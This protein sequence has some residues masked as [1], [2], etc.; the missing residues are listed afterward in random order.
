MKTFKL[1][2][3]E[4]ATGIT[5]EVYEDIIKTWGKH[6]LVPV[7]GFWGNDHV[8]VKA[9]WD[10]VKHLKVETTATPKKYL[11]AISLITAVQN[12]CDRCVNTHERE[13]IRDLG[14]T[15]EFVDAVKNYEE[16]YKAGK[17]DR[18]YYLALELGLAVAEGKQV[19]D[20][21]WNGLNDCFSQ[22]QIYE[23][24]IIALLDSC[25]SR[26]GVAM[27]MFED[28]F[29]WPEEYTPSAKYREVMK[30]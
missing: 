6:R 8:V 24:I 27:A 29:D 14:L 5:K 9:M 17:L 20:E 11:F 10:V 1:V 16:S 21:L 4:Q 30:K 23:M 3:P 28:S 2:K 25:F 15:K 18:E 13:L 22:K 26:Y 12:D 19:S 7:W